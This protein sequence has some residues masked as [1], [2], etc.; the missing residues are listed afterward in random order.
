MKMNYSHAQINLDSRLRLFSR[1]QAFSGVE[2]SDIAIL[3]WEFQLKNKA[4]KG[5]SLQNHLKCFHNGIIL[6]VNCFKLYYKITKIL[7]RHNEYEKNFRIRLGN[8]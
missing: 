8:K 3:D 6:I 1:F 4:K 2:K 5:D 7:I